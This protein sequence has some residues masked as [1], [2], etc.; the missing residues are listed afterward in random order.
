V[1]KAL[2]AA[3]LV[4]VREQARYEF[5]HRI[6]AAEQM[7]GA[8]I[9]LDP[10]VLT[11]GF[12]RRFATYKQANLLF[13]DVERL[14]NIIT[15]PERPVQVV[16]AGKAHPADNPGKQVLQ[17]VYQATRDPRFQGRVA[18]IED[19]D[20]HL[21]HVLVQGVDLWLNVPR[22][23]ME[24]S[25]TSGMKA[26]LNGVP[27]LSTMDGWWAEGFDGANGWSLAAPAPDVE[28]SETR[29]GL[30]HGLYALLEREVV[31]SFYERN[32]AGIPAR[33]VHMMKHALRAAGTHFTARR[34]LIDYVRKYYVP[35]MRGH[36]PP[37][38][39]PTA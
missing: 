2:K 19:Y 26:A 9:L 34:M 33:W 23:P 20:M 27:Q 30:A 4:Y 24:A 22:P 8:G 29:E 7:V 6:H 35:S 11:I 21:A 17:E 18:F 15:D 32:P 13:H 39:P 25:G 37:D 3:L 28:Q 38:E 12:A 5:S 14:L 31:P 10:D 16:F 36:E 1:H